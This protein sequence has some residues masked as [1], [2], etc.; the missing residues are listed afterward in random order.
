LLLGLFTAL[1]VQSAAGAEGSPAAGK[2]QPAA[3][4]KTPENR[5]LSPFTGYTRDH[6]LEITEKLIAGVLPY[7]DAETGLPVLKG[8]PSETGHFREPF[9]LNG[10][11]EALERS[12]MLAAFYTAATGRDRVP[13]YKG[14]IT[15]PYLRGI[16]RGT[17][18]DSPDYWG[19]REKYDAFG[20]NLALAVLVSPRFFWDPL[21]TEQKDNLLD[22][23]QDLSETVAYD[24]NHW[25]FHLVAV[26]VLEKNGRDSNRDYLTMIFQRLLNWYRGDGWFID[27]GNFG[28]DYY[29]LWGF[30]LYNHALCY[31]D[32]PWNRSFSARI[33][34]IT[35]MFLQ[36]FP[37]LYGRDGG[38]VPWGR[39]TTY[40]F[41]SLSALAWA[42]LRGAGTLDPGQARRIA[43]GC[44]K[45]FWERGAMSE[46]GLL[47]PGFHGP[48]SV[49]AENYIDRGSPYWAA[50]GLACLLIPQ[51]HPFWIATEKPM[52]ADG[53]GGRIAL[54][55]AQ[56]TIKVSPVDGEARLY[57]VGQ[58][59]GHYG[60]WQRGIKYC[61]HAY[62]SYL[63]YCATGEGGEDLGAGRTGTSFDGKRW[64]YRSRPQAVQVGTSHLVSR[65]EIYVDTLEIALEDFGELTTH[66]L[67][68]DC[69]EVHVFW[70]NSARP[71]YLHLGGYG[72]RVAHGGKLEIQSADNTLLLGSGGNHSVLRLLQGPPGAIRHLL[73]EPRP[74]WAN[75]HSFGG[76]GAFCYWRSSRP[77][78]PNTVVAAYVDGTCGRA[79]VQPE[80]T[81]HQARD[82]LQVRF[83]G[84]TYRIKIPY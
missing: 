30:Q 38:P 78:P 6:W 52:P 1:P 70:H 13:G 76:K 69:G 79:P 66:T 37:Y 71:I 24:C 39:S 51:D 54:P 11:K 4:L 59:L 26:P 46:N 22:F 57:P 55:G 74:G 58:P 73:L 56:M 53:A 47:E 61:Q 10:R 16:A 3:V 29:N 36:S 12:L 19:D 8:V 31:F 27:G 2:M 77:V 68:G 72:I 81:L 5:S 49:V 43:S 14:S 17:D 28:F 75:S 80:I 35:G 32:E 34:E 18:P 20:T 15:A 44:L 67:I 45:Y 84:E 21:T 41:A 60:Q 63:G 82:M 23:F 9:S 48:N 50:Q 33:D 42:V 62:S 7:F 83:D 25:Y 65:E 40:R 64:H